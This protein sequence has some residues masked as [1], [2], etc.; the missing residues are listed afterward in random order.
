MEL[1]ELHIDNLGSGF[2]SQGN[3]VSGGY[4]GIGGKFIELS[5]SAG[6]QYQV[7]AFEFFNGAF[8]AIENPDAFDPI[9]FNED[10]GCQV[11]FQHRQFGCSRYSAESYLYMFSG[12]IASGM[13]DARYA[14]G[15]LECKRNFS[16]YGIER[17][18]EIDQVGN[19][20]GSF[21]SENVYYL[22]IAKPVAGDNGVFIMQLGGIV[23]TDS[24]GDSALCVA[25]IAVFN[26]A[27]GYHKDTA[28]LLRQQGAIQAC[29][30][31]A[32]YDVI[33]G[34]NRATSK[35]R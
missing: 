24:S 21:V 10:I 3:S 26:T 20:V 31:A 15:C 29:N 33:I 35:I 27:L 22:F 9:L 4:R 28:V 12:G 16:V 8:F 11:V 1:E 17:H 25:G 18:T 5:G 14:V 30:T 23:D 32:D 2:Q 6:C 34:I 13:Q 7:A 19:S